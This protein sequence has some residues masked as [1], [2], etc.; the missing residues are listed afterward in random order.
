MEEVSHVNE[1]IELEEVLGLQ[2][3]E[4]GLEEVDPTIVS[5]FE[6]HID[7]ETNEWEECI[8]EEESEEKESEDD[9]GNELDNSSSE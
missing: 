4:A 8:E 7:E 9:H 1:I 2:D 5:S 3:V 6:G